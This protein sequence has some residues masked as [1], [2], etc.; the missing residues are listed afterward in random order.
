MICVC[1]WGGGGS[2]SLLDYLTNVHETFY[3]NY[4]LNTTTVIK[5]EH[6][7]TGRFIMH[8]IPDARSPVRLNFV[9][10]RPTPDGPQC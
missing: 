1:V 9:P 3:E 8:K 5:N 10:W 2:I 7:Y 4:C 6:N